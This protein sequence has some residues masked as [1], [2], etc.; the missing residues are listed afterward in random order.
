MLEPIFDAGSGR[1]Y[2]QQPAAAAQ[3]GNQ[4]DD[5]ADAGKHGTEREHHQPG[6]PAEKA[7]FDQRSGEQHEH[8]GGDGGAGDAP[9]PGAGGLDGHG[10]LPFAGWRA[11]LLAAGAKVA[12]K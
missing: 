2:R 7:I 6:L 4:A 11:T 8:G 10:H 1:D 5:A 3:H 9:G 12:P